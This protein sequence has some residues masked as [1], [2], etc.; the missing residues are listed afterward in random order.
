MAV[1]I[2]QCDGHGIDLTHGVTP[3]AKAFKAFAAVFIDER[4]G[5]DTARGIAGAQDENVQGRFCHAVASIPGTFGSAHGG[6]I[7]VFILTLTAVFCEIGQQAV[8]GIIIGG[9]K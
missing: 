6:E 5:E 9:I 7:A 8:H 2:E 3:G 1:G 4:F